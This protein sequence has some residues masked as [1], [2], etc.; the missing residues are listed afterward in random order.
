M[1]A[2]DVDGAGPG[3]TGPIFE[4][5]G[6]EAGLDFVH[7][8]GMSGKR[9]FVEM[10]GAGAGLL[11]YD[12]DG[13]LDLYLVQGGPLA[14]A[15]PSVGAPSDRLYRNDWTESGLLRFTDVTAETGLAGATGYGMGVSTGDYDN[16]GDVDLYLSNWGANQLWRNE[17]GR[18]VDATAEAGEGMADPGWSAGATFF[19]YDRDGWLDLMIVNYDA[20]S[21]AA[22]VDCRSPRSGRLDYCGPQSYPAQPDRLMHNLGDGSFEDVTA[23]MGIAAAFGPAL[24]VVAADLDA[25]GW[26]DLYVANDGAENQQ[27]MNR[28][29]RR[30]E[31]VAPAMGSALSRD[32]LTQASMGLLAEDVDADGDIDLFST[33]LERETNTLYVN[34]GTGFFEDRSR[35]SGLG[36]ASFAMTGFG[37]AALDYDLDGALDIAVSNGEVRLIEEQAAAGEELPLAQPKQLFR[38]LG[39]GSFELVGAEAGE[40]FARLEVGRGLA[41]GDLDQDGDVDLLSSQNGGPAW[42]LVNRVGQDAAWIGARLLGTDARRDMLGARAALLVGGAG[43]DLAAISQARVA[44]DG[45][46]GSARDPRVRFG[47]GQ[48]GDAEGRMLGIR[49]WWPDGLAEDFGDLAPGRYHELLQGEGSPLG[50]ER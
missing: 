25:D 32:G 17:G 15:G 35:T 26:Q 6:P 2:D 31:D 18:F 7:D 41:A 42:V 49:V 39:E 47:L 44:T 12:G 13:D 23:Q 19:D 24:G 3:P 46:Y 33:H 40:A 48:A 4:A 20:Y 36:Q 34:D 21:L 30:F 22:H 9:W 16:D 8:N 43:S 11:D 50:A 37:V 10:M 45:S 5:L 14:D 1:P 29:G 27:W 28:E 38:G